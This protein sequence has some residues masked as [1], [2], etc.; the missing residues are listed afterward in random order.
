MYTSEGM[1]AVARVRVLTGY[2]PSDEGS[3]MR[4]SQ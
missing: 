4:F 1:C 2:S 3:G